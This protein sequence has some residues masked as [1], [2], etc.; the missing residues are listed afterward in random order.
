MFFRH[1]VLDCPM[2]LPECQLSS[3]MGTESESEW[4]RTASPRHSPRNKS[5]GSDS[6][7]W[8]VSPE[9]HASFPWLWKVPSDEVAWLVSRLWAEVGQVNTC[10]LFAWFIFLFFSFYNGKSCSFSLLIRSI[11]CSHLMTGVE[12]L[13]MCLFNNPLCFMDADLSLGNTFQY[14]NS[15]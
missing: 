13:I 1:L 10:A 2:A 6:C 8:W 15:H 11:N 5:C 12:T 7:W 3:A 9:T 4:P 14:L